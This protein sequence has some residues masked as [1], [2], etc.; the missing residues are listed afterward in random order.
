MSGP[1]QPRDFEGL[2]KFCIEATKAEDAPDDPDAALQA[3]DPER[4]QWLEQALNSMSVDVI[5]GKLFDIYF[6]T[7]LLLFI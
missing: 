5:K 6:C 2:L 7:S 1:R 3:M 4:R